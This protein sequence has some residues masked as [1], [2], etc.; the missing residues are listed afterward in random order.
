MRWSSLPPTLPPGLAPTKASP[1]ELCVQQDH[2][3]PI[4][5]RAEGKRH[6][7]HDVHEE[8]TGVPHGLLEGLAAARQFWGDSS[9]LPDRGSPGRPPDHR[10]GLGHGV[11]RGKPWGGGRGLT[12]WAA[13]TAELASRTLSPAAPHP[14]RCRVIR[15]AAATPSSRRPTLLLTAWGPAAAPGGPAALAPWGREQVGEE[16]VSTRPGHVQNSPRQA[17]SN[18]AGRVARAG[19]GVG[20]G[21]PCRCEDRAGTPRVA[22]AAAAG[23]RWW[24]Q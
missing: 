17:P 14:A 11:G 18:R 13:A 22:G 9:Q 21:Q 15:L 8:L 24:G 5:G 23:T 3:L 10:I 19:R 6:E 12:A 1:C 20:V 16:T 2:R 7:S 4:S